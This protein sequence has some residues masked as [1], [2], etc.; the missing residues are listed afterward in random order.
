MSTL[1]KAVKAASASAYNED[2][3]MIVGYQPSLGWLY[4]HADDE[5]A[6]AD[7]E[8]SFKVNSTG[9]DLRTIDE[10]FLEQDWDNETTTATFPTGDKI[11]FSGPDQEI[12]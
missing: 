6:I 10:Q 9:V 1:K 12:A 2:A 5:A 4:R 11:V 3:D 7:L 8:Y